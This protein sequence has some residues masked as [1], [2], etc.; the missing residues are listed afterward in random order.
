MGNKNA[1][2]REEKKQAKPKPKKILVQKRDDSSQ[3]ASRIGKS[4]PDRD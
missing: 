2:K 4:E 1:G 3:A